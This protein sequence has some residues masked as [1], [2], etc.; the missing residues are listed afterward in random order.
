MEEYCGKR[1]E[2]GKEYRNGYA[3]RTIVT[4]PGEITFIWRGLEVKALINR[5]IRKQKEV[6]VRHQSNLS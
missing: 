3:K 6:P 2:R 4:L 1:Y 5:R